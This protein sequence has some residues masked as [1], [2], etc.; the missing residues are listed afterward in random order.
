M[1]SISKKVIK[2]AGWTAIMSYF[3]L[4][5]SFGGNFV[6][7][8]LLAPQDF[9]TYALASSILT[10][11]FM[12]AGFGSQD[13]IVQCRDETVEDLIPTA[14]WLTVGLAF[15]LA[16]VGTLVGVALNQVYHQ[17]VALLIIFLAWTLFFNNLLYAY[18]AILQRELNY[19]LISLTGMIANLFSFGLAALLAAYGVGLW[20]LLFRDIFFTAVSFWLVALF[21][22]QVIPFR[23]N[24]KTALW[25]WHFGWH[26]MV[27]RMIQVLFERLDNLFIGLFLGPAALGQYSLAYRLLQLIYQ[28]TYGVIHSVLFSALS[29][30]QSTKERLNY[31]TER[32]NYWLYRIVILLGLGVFF[33]GE[34]L[35]TLFYGQKWHEAGS[36]FALFA[37]AAMLLP[38]NENLKIALVSA[39]RVSSVT[40]AS[41]FQLG[42][43]VLAIIVSTYLKN[44]S[45]VVGVVDLTLLIYW[46]GLARS[47][48]KLIKID[49]V[50]LLRGPLLATVLVELSILGLSLLNPHLDLLSQLLLQGGLVVGVFGL[51]LW[52]VEGRALKTEISLLQQALGSGRLA[53]TNRVIA[54]PSADVLSQPTL[55]SFSSMPMLV[56]I[57]KE[58][59]SMSS[60]TNVLI[61]SVLSLF[62][63]VTL[64]VIYFTDPAVLSE[65]FAWIAY[66][67]SLGLLTVVLLLFRALL[68]RRFPGSPL[69]LHPLFLITAWIILSLGLPGLYGYIDDSILRSL[70]DTI[71]VDY[72]YASWGMML[73]LVGVVALWISYALGIHLFKPLNFAKRLS[74]QQPKLTVLMVFYAISLSFQLLRIMVTGVS[75]G[76]DRSNW[77][78]FTALDQT[79]GYV[80]DTRYLIMAIVAIGVFQ[81]KW[82]ASALY[83]ILATQLILGFTSGTMKPV[84]WLALV[85]LLCAIVA[86]LSLRRLIIPAVI[87]GLL[88]ILVIPVTER[89]RTER[90]SLDVRNPAEVLQNT[91]RAFDESWGSGV[92]VG[93]QLFT[94]KALS[95]QAILAYTPGIVMSVTPSVIPYDGPE[96]FLNIVS[97]IVPRFIW[98]DKPVLSKGRDYNIIYFNAPSDTISAS[99][100]TIF[101]ESYTFAGWG[102]TI[103]ACLVLGLMLALI[104]RNTVSVGL[105]ALLIALVPTFLDIESQYSTMIVYLVQRTPVLFGCLWLIMALSNRTAAERAESAVASRQLSVK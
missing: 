21:S 20:S 33:T 38:L 67:V 7:A 44:I 78:S 86:R 49:W 28:V 26:L 40:T 3:N 81:R 103:F 93:W 80:E 60:R 22:A 73:I 25:V 53:K 104:Y 46:F 11:I 41:L 15:V 85:L 56:E 69:L 57:R 36:L 42:F 95:R 13:A 79:I 2:G 5:V 10:L 43:F 64:L 90:G 97:Y 18:H 62:V 35:V 76:A 32:I 101:A 51:A 89:W 50:Y 87:M 63:A 75:Y 29:L 9:G 45:L 74:Q 30:L 55:S 27:T 17:Q 92:D 70:W 8:Y 84:F 39:G 23:F 12:V 72:A 65:N 88:V 71:G 19:R 59:F 61:C 102:G 1:S 94:T 66:L 48:S 100:I 58:E 96:Q 68:V 91:A 54:L 77:G 47:A 99:A 16:T 37:L 105:E 6:L 14:F 52:L 34:P 4:I 83:P 24:R 31:A 82:S 98:P